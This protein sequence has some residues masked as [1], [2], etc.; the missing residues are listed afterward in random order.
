MKKTGILNSHISKVLSDLGHTDKIVIADAGL[1]IPD[2]VLRIDVSLKQGVP[3]FWEVLDTILMDMVV[4]KAVFAEEVKVE[5]IPVY[6]EITRKL[7]EVALEYVSHDRFKLLTKDAKVIIRT[8][9]VTP[10]ANCIL[11]SGVFF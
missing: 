5:N 6:Q 2:G 7:S 8:G 4:E 1:P 9:E 11:S 10:Y 3:S